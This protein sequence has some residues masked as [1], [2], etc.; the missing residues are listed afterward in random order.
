V[1]KLQAKCTTLLG[2][3]GARVTEVD[4]L[5]LSARRYSGASLSGSRYAAAASARARPLTAA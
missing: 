3:E 2:P 1:E 5:V 4:R